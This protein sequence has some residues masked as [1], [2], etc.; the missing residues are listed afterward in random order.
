MIYIV[1]WVICGFI[2]SVI[3]GSKGRSSGAFFFL[4]ILF[5]PIGIIIAAVI[6]KNDLVI[7]K[8]AIQNG[9]MKKC[10]KCAEA[11]KAEAVVCRYCSYEFGAKNEP[12][13]GEAQPNEM[14][15]VDCGHCSTTINYSTKLAGTTE[16]CPKCSNLMIFPA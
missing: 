2:C 8:D 7:E 10:P 1:V 6:P 3:A 4:G 9:H 5:G 11:I 15:Q 12:I 16:R 14:K 13:I